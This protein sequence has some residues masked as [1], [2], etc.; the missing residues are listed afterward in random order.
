MQNDSNAVVD[1]ITLAGAPCPEAYRGL[2]NGAGID[3]PKVPGVWRSD[4]D[5]RGRG[6]QTVR[7]VEDA[8]VAALRRHQRPELR[9]GRPILQDGGDTLARRCEVARLA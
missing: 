6:R 3:A 4:F 7:V 1:R 5:D 2:A 8:Y 9:Q